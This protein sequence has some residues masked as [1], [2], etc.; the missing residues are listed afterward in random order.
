MYMYYAMC[1]INTR[2]VACGGFHS[3]AITL[4]YVALHY[5]A[6]HFPHHFSLVTLQVAC[7]GFHSAAI[8][9][10]GELYTCVM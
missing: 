2:Q 10:G 5:I 1:V 8:T 3:A 6:L 4:H 7:G 9:E